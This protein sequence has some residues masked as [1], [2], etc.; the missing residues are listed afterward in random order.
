M[1]KFNRKVNNNNKTICK[2][3]KS[4]NKTVISIISIIVIMTAMF[5]AIIV[6]KPK[7]SETPQDITTR[8]AD[9]NIVD[10]CTEEYQEIQNE[11]LQ[12]NVQEEKISPNASITLKKNYK[13]CGHMTSQYLEISEELVNKTKE[14]LQK[15]YEGWNIE[16]FS[17]TEIILNKE[18]EGECGEHYIVR[19]NN[20]KVT[21]YEMLEDG[22]EKEYEITD[23]ST[24][25]LTETDKINMQKGIQV[26]G[27][28]A[29]N[30]LIEDFE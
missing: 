4:M 6:Y 24:E 19:D 20:G 3:V 2:G 13:K 16:K 26:N 29:L 8:V 5:I 11:I 30:Q 28:Q 18:E 10:E 9:E 15:K 7:E 21:V 22:S 12:T 27:K 25:Y 1:Y 14:D 23:I 17:D